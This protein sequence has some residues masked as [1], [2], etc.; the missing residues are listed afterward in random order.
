M[1]ELF[2][3]LAILLII[4]LG[5]AGEIFK[6]IRAN[7]QQK[8]Q[9]KTPP[10]RPASSYPQTESYNAPSPKTK[11]E[12]DPITTVFR[13]LFEL[14]PKDVVI[15]DEPPAPPAGERVDRPKQPNIFEDWRNQSQR[16]I[17]PFRPEAY[18]DKPRQPKPA[19][20][21]K[22][23]PPKPKDPPPKVAQKKIAASEYLVGASA[24]SPETQF[25][26]LYDRYG[27]KPLKLA[28]IYN[29][30]LGRPRSMRNTSPRRYT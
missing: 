6:K 12:D 8:P 16:D 26:K 9:P 27:D 14:E 7:T 4:L 2:K 11:K 29:E 15:V 10:K 20:M 17:P 3:A 23:K 19:Q 13:E 1:D 18:S 28:V 30:I 5:S 24:A 22:P 21:A 25:Q